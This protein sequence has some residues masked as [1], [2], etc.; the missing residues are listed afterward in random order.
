ME[1]VKYGT[2][3]IWNMSNME[4]VKYGTCQIWNM[5]N[6]IKTYEWRE[7]MKPEIT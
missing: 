2:C 1:H 6:R 4:H 5:S 7:L 3:Q